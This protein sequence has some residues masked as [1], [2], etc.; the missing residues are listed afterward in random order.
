MKKAVNKVESG[1]KK[2]MK[3]MSLGA[4]AICLLF[5]LVCLVG[6]I[7]YIAS[8]K[9]KAAD[10]TIQTDDG[11]TLA[12]DEAYELKKGSMSLELKYGTEI[13]Y[14]NADDFQVVWSIE[15]GSDFID[16]SA[17]S[18]QVYQ[19]VTAKAPGEAVI[20]VIVY[21]KNRDGT[22][23]TQQSS[24][25]GR[26]R[27]VF[28]VDTSWNN[29]IFKY[30]YES[31][32]DRSLV[33]YAGN[34]S[35]TMKLNFGS[36]SD[37]QWEMANTEVA[38]VE[39][40]TGKVSAVGAGF[41]TMTVTYTPPGS[42]DTYSATLD[43]YV[44][45]RASGTDSNFS[46]APTVQLDSGEYIYTDTLFTNNVE[47][48][49]SK[50]YWSIRQEDGSGNRV[51]IANS[52]NLES[53]LI[54]ITPTSS[55]SN[56][57]QVIGTAGV[58]YVYFY[59]N[60]PSHA[61]NL[62]DLNEAGSYTPTIMNITIISPIEDKEVTLGIG[63]VLSL[64]QSYNMTVSDFLATF[65]VQVRMGKDGTGDTAT[66]YATYNSTS[67]DLTALREGVIYATMT[68]KTGKE[69]YVKNLKGLNVDDTIPSM[70]NTKITI[71]DGITMGSES[72]VIM[73]G[74]E[75]QLSASLHGT[76][77]G[78]ITWRSSNNSFV[79]VDESG[80]IKGI[81]VTTSDVTVSASVVVTG[82]VTRTASC[83][84]KV[85][86]A[87][88]SFTLNPNTKQTMNVGDYLTVVA[89]IKETVSQAPLEWMSSDE[90]VVTV[91]P[92]ADGKSAIVYGK[93]GGTARLIV[94]NTLNGGRVN[95]DIEVVV[96]LDTLKFSADEATYRYYQGGHNMKQ[97]LTTGPANATSKTLVWSVS[98]TAVATI[99]EEGY[100][101]FKKPG[102]IV[103]SVKPEYNPN[104]LL[105]Q[106]TITIT[107]TGC[108]RT[109]AC[110]ERQ[111][112]AGAQAQELET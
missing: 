103:L 100:L 87:M 62:T 28:S 45:P 26:I 86:A 51:E 64:A 44:I 39:R 43:V 6:G 32:S 33:M 65:S 14:E 41:T 63:D 24:V 85:E 72:V 19:N 34:T 96:P 91:E 89:T 83:Q 110:G 25:R 111:R 84:V 57:M 56:Q 48:V 21:A 54:S 109:Q 36:S 74:Q 82:G 13:H 23:G 61:S 49:R 12:L 78:A 2:K 55:T 90:N 70:F 97:E 80:L 31:D 29:E 81:K 106:M 7:Y 53:D 104:L 112:I 9:A 52:K 8:D 99:D 108:G 66:N 101:S 59:V 67:T 58:Y 92:A 102:V 68:V 47:V 93:A 5:G 20:S 107:G 73:V 98:N 27:V 94:R 76:Y 3:G 46:T 1:M 71:I 16:I 35:Q 77:T 4:K 60:N 30:V 105:A 75:Y 79:T 95:L 88:T 22:L 18:G 50:I 42:T 17:G 15:T 10:V 69:N 11:K 38:T 40:T 37:A